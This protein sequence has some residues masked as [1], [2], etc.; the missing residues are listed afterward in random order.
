MFFV[1]IEDTSYPPKISFFYKVLN[2]KFSILQCVVYIWQNV[3][4]PILQK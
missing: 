4:Y 3:T 2:V 1:L